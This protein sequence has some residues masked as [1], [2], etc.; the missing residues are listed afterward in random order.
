MKYLPSNLVQE[1]KQ[2]IVD[3]VNTKEDKVKVVDTIEQTTDEGIYIIE[4]DTTIYDDMLANGARIE[5]FIAIVDT[6]DK[7]TNTGI[8]IIMG[9]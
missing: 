8:W 6:M 1:F 9:E 7:T 4:D 3:K 5:S 2:W